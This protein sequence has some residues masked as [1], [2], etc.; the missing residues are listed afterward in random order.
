MKKATHIRLKTKKNVCVERYGNTLVVYSMNGTVKGSYES[1]QLN[2]FYKRYK[3][4]VAETQK[5]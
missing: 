1:T 4:L 2:I 3:S 5:Y